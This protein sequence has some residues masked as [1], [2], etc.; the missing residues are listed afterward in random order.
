MVVQRGRYSN[1][2]LSRSHGLRLLMHADFVKQ[3]QDLQRM[4]RRTKI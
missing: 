2:P 3:V 1:L 4:V